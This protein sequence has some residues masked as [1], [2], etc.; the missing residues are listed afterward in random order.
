MGLTFSL[1][2]L[3]MFRFKSQ[4]TNSS[5]NWRIDSDGFLRVTMCV[6]RAGVFKYAKKDLPKEI[7]D[8]KPEIEVWR[9]RVPEKSFSDD[10]LKSAEGKPAIAYDH[11]W[12]GVDDFN[13]NEVKGSLAGSAVCDGYEMTIDAVITDKD[14]I[15]AVKSGE[16][17]EISAGYH[18]N[19]DLLADDPEADAVQIPTEMN[20]VVLLPVGRG[21]C[22]PSVRI[23]NMKG[24]TKMSVKV[25]MKNSAGE[26]QSYE[27]TNEA[28]AQTAEKMAQDQSAAKGAQMEA[29]N[30]ELADAQTKFA[31]I[32][33][34]LTALNAEKTILEQKI[35]QYESEEYQETQAQ[36]RDAY[37][38]DESAVIENACNEA[39]KKDLNAKLQNAKSVKERREIVT[40]TICNSKG[41]DYKPENAS[42]LFGVL[43]KTMNKASSTVVRKPA[44][45]KFKN[46][47]GTDGDFVHPIMR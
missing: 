2:I 9:V 21:R 44:Q 41:I 29:K 32:N 5:G 17:C 39:E 47:D 16:L 27:F 15:E 24:E 33:K 20:H 43:C 35:K 25:K 42:I 11:E 7:T 1:N 40:A 14:T 34:V 45:A 13:P 19:V 12:Q 3:P 26:E 6:L 28:D 10:F 38:A 22:G 36:E 37:K 30:H 46:S 18:S 31:E 4:I 23:L 8:L